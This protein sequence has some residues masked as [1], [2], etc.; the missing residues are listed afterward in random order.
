MAPGGPGVEC[1]PGADAVLR[2]LT[3]EAERV[4]GRGQISE[5]GR[6]LRRIWR[7]WRMHGTLDLLLVTR[8]A[9]TF[10]MWYSSD[11]IL[12]VAAV[13]GILLLAERFQGIGPWSKLDVVFLLGYASLVGGI[14]GTFFSYN[15]S[16]I[17]RRLGRGQLDHTLF[18]PQPMWMSSLPRASVR[19][20][21]RRR[22]Y[23]AWDS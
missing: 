4:R 1:D 11:M 14:V 3:M 8:D 5:L 7:L 13:T 10:L 9:K 21:D 6:I 23:R 12:N 15:I 2:W 20:L 19:R 17:S 18:Q 16:M 22:S